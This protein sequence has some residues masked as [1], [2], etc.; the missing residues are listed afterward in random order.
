MVY[1][2][3]EIEYFVE[4]EN[5]PFIVVVLVTENYH[6]KSIWRNASELTVCVSY[7]IRARSESTRTNIFIYMSI[8]E[9]IS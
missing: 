6:K 9:Y 2:L 3:L 7:R 5:K 1:V 4:I 8:Y